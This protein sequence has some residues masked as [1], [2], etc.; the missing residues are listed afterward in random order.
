MASPALVGEA[1]QVS[2][3]GDWTLADREAAKDS[4]GKHGRTVAVD[5]VRIKGGAEY[6]IFP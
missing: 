6:F 2:E 4:G 3:P 5:S 1:H